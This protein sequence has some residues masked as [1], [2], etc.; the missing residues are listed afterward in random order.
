MIFRIGVRENEKLQTAKCKF[1]IGNQAR[2]L[3]S[4]GMR[5]CQFTICILHFAI[6]NVLILIIRLMSSM[7]T[8]N[9]LLL[10]AML[11]VATLALRILAVVGGVAVGGL[12]TGWL[13]KVLTRP[14]MVKKL[15][16]PLLRVSRILGGLVV[17]LI[18]AAWV[19]NLGGT[20]GIGGS[21]GGWWPFGQSG[22]P[23]TSKPSNFSDSAR[24]PIQPQTS[25]E[26]KTLRIHM[27]GGVQAEKDNRFYRIEG[28]PARTWPEMEQVLAERKKND[29]SLVLEIIISKGSVDEQSEAVHELKSWAKRNSV[30]VK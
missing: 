26:A 20:G 14:V 5:S 7:Q 16:T 17:G 6:C 28:E 19:F 18:V 9:H 29:P 2:F 15:P 27:E 8:I 12:G 3:D 10:F 30:A 24:A 23:G 25:S 11:D 22:G 21:G 1:E 4:P 13:V